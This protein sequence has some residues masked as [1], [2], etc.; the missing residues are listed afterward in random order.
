M[1]DKRSERS[2]IE[3]IVRVTHCVIRKFSQGDLVAI[4]GQDKEQ[5]PIVKSKQVLAE[6]DYYAKEGYPVILSYAGNCIATIKDERNTYVIGPVRT[7]IDTVSLPKI[8]G[9]LGG[10]VPDCPIDAWFEELAL[11]QNLV[12]QTDIEPRNIYLAN[13]INLREVRENEIRLV[14]Y[15]NDNQENNFI[16]NP[17]DQEVRELSSI[18]SGN[19]ERLYES[20][21]ETFVGDYA[22]LGPNKLRSLKNLAILDLGLVARAAIRGGVYYEQAFSISDQY[23]RSVENAKTEEEVRK[24]VFDAKVRYTQLVQN[25]TGPK[26]EN[27]IIKKCKQ[28][29]QTHLHNEI[30]LVV[31]AS[32]CRVSPQYLSMLFQVMSVTP[33]W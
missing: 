13:K 17:Y 28:Y 7:G 27:L 20:L 6:L 19:M 26:S 9:S 11:L 22:T 14:K 15:L 4:Y 33:A 31:V 18:E 5:D 1:M 10:K 16:H 21:H 2:V 23:I 32:Y 29:I 30:K 3:H 25:Q 12:A 24:L 8:S